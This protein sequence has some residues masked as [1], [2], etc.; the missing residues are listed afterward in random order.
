MPTNPKNSRFLEK[1][2]LRAVALAASASAALAAGVTTPAPASAEPVRGA[3]I[4]A[5]DETP[6]AAKDAIEQGLAKL[7]SMQ[8]PDGSFDAGPYGQNVGISSLACMAFLA[9][10]N[11]PGRGRYGDNV[12]RGLDFVLANCTESGLIAADVSRGPM[13]GHGFATLLLGEVYGMTGD[14]RIREPLLKAVRLILKSQNHEGGWRYQ[15]IPF[16]ADISVTICQ[17][18]ALRS[19]RNAGVAVPAETIDA[20]TQYVLA[21]Q[22]ASDG[23]FRYR[24]NSGPS[25]FERT[26]AGVASLFYAGVYDG[27]DVAAGMTYLRTAT[28]SIGNTGYFYYGHYYGSQAMFLAGG[29]D[30]SKYFPA[31]RDYLVNQQSSD[32][33]WRSGHG[34]AYATAMALIILQMPN[35]LLPIYQR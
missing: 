20:A 23:G 22:N 10:G 3:E 28:A 18:M 1:G 29:E 5:F 33:S 2:S 12:K 19:A 7:A 11:L 21:C 32:G 15:P 14:D 25:G 26:A 9:D 34:N 24:T 30:W 31:V 4:A 35:R 17:I 27:P 8:R 13:Y 16:D 6:A